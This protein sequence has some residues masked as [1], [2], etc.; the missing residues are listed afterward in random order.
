[1]RLDSGETRLYGLT[2]LNVAAKVLPTRERHATPAAR[3]L[4]A[5][6]EHVDNARRVAGEGWQLPS[7]DAYACPE[8]PDACD[9][10]PAGLGLAGTVW[11]NYRLRGTLTD[12][13]D[14]EG[15]PQRLGNS[16][17]EAGLQST[18]SCM[19]CHARAALAVADGRPRRM[20]V[21]ATSERRGSIG[22]PEP[23]WYR[24]DG[25]DY[26]SLDFVWSLSQ[27]K[28][29]RTAP[30]VHPDRQELSSQNLGDGR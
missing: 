4:W 8:T 13:V 23:A 22:V 1:V 19:T 3:W 9:R 27:A 2:A 10:V 12:Y 20:S 26:R 25:L 6:F 7:R 17:L 29:R 11:Q 5:S 15:R 30:L 16:E 28:P 14:A 24:A 18:S 21:F